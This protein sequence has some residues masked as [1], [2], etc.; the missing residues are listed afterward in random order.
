MT[1]KNAYI[2]VET[3]GLNPQKSALLQIGCILEIDGE[4]EEELTY[5]IQPHLKDELDPK[6]L[7]VNGLT[8]ETIDT[9]ARPMDSYTAFTSCMGE[10]VNKFDRKDKFHF[11]GYNSQAFDAPFIRAFFGKCKD[12]YYGSWFFHPTIDVMILAAHSL[13]KTRHELPNFKLGTV[14]KALGVDFDPEQLHDAMYDIK[15]TREV[16]RRL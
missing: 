9:F 16:Y 3:G 14:A 4:I 2:D 15:V 8:K 10:Y 1:V 13:R 6:A 7:A 12:K 11:I 5:N